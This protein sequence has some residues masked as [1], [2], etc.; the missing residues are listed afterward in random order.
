MSEPPEVPPARPS[1]VSE[2]A[3]VVG[4]RFEEV[5]MA[6]PV[7]EEELVV[8][9]RPVIRE[10]LR[11]RRRVVEEEEVFEVDLRKEEVDVEDTSGRS[12]ED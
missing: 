11:I 1:P 3:R 7:I 2:S 8:K 9:K 5:D 4:E 6:V 10:E 12:R